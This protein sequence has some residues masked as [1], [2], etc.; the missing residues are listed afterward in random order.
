VGSLVGRMVVVEFVIVAAVRRREVC[1]DMLDGV[2]GNAD[3]D[4]NGDCRGG[5]RLTGPQCYR[6]GCGGCEVDAIAEKLSRVM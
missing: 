2:F 3:V 4:N 6:G 5:R 1:I